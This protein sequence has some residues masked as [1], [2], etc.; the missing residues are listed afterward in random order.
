V[1]LLRATMR[2]WLP[3]GLVIGL[4][5]WLAWSFGGVAPPFGAAPSSMPN[6]ED[7]KVADGIYTSEYFDLSYPL[8]QG[9]NEGLAGP[10]PSYSGYYSLKTLIPTDE[11]DATIL[12]AAQDMFFAAKPSRD[13]AEAA[14]DFRQ[15]MSQIDGMTIDRG[16]LEM[17]IADRAFQRVDFSGVGL[18]RAMFV[19]EIRCHLVS[20]NLTTRDPERLASLAR[21]LDN[22]S[23]VAKTDRS[24][25][26]ACMENY[27]VAEN[28]LQKV[29][30]AIVDTAFASIPVRIIIGTDGSVK[31][32]HVIRAAAQQ[33]ENIELALRQWRFRPHEVHGRAIEVETGLVFRRPNAIGSLP[34]TPT[35]QVGLSVR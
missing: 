23:Y 14:N 29:E 16:P 13:A 8:P 5:G 33:R 1:T 35:E 20:F 22:V 25:Q 17:Q 15:A 21:S 2:R 27:T 12:I 26:P 10:D 28:L 11:P 18:Y 32:V 9:W 7:G 19:V 30:P 4:L 3:L 6:P 31:H 24:A 34:A